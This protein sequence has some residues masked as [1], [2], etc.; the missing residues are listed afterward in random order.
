MLKIISK[1]FQICLIVPILIV[2]IFVILIQSI[3]ILLSDIPFWL[4]E[5]NE[6]KINKRDKK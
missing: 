2:S 1:L 3:Y 4:L 5:A 6:N